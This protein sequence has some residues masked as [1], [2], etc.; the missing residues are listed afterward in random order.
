MKIPVTSSLSQDATT[1]SGGFGIYLPH[2]FTGA[3]DELL[4]CRETAWL[5]TSLNMSPVYDVTGPD[6]AKLLTSICVN[7]DFSKTTEKGTRH[8]IICNE[9]GLML[10]DGVA[11]KIN[12]NVFRTYWLAPVLA[13]YVD[14]SDLDVSGAYVTEEEEYFFQ[15]DGPKSLE[16]LEDACQCDIHDLKFAQHKLVDI[17]GSKMRIIRLGMSGALGYELHGPAEDM[18]MIYSKLKESGKKFGMRQ[19]GSRHYCVNHTQAGYPNQSIHFQF[20]LLESGESLKKYIDENAKIHP[21]PFIY[22]HIGGSCSDD[23]SNFYV[24]PFDVGWGFLVK[25]DHD[26][27]GREALE[28]IADNPPNVP[29]T[30]EWNADDVGDIFASQ[31]RGAE[32]EPFDEIDTPWDGSDT[33]VNMIVYGMDKVFAQDTLIGRS[34]GRIHDYYHRRMITI[35]YL[36]KEFAIEGNEV[37]ILFGSPGHPQKKVRATISRF[38]YYNGEYRNETFDTRNIPRL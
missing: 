11:Y 32:V 5:G 24:T 16:I 20:P 27:I 1:I 10:A 7:R 36:K 26:F 12:D 8:A 2:N 18:D 21:N 34:A 6:A 28:K 33:I 17:D 22:N 14:K 4:A 23:R 9:K 38:P 29:V 31:F 25:F 13:Y 35:G 3:K 15:L 19:L 30:L 37:T